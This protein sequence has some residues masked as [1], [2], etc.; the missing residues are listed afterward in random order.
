M[1]NSISTIGE[2]TAPNAAEALAESTGI[3]IEQRTDIT[4]D[5]LERMSLPYPA[6]LY[7][8]RIVYKMSNFEH[9]VIHENV[10]YKIRNYLESHPVG[11]LSGNAN[12]RLR[13]DRKRDSRAPDISFVVND[14]LPQSRR[15]YLPMAPDLAIEILSPV[16]SFDKVMEKVEEYLQAGVKNVWLIIAST[17]EVLVCRPEGK[18]SVRDV[19]TAPELL[20]GFELPVQDIFA[21]VETAATSK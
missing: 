2:S 12:Y 5:E 17:R 6:E 14:R 15:R 19:L 8:G 16:D 1:A 13:P 7:D 18:H 21:G 9:G 10:A 20:P 4:V 3:P 11:L